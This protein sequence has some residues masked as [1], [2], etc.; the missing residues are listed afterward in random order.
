MS[1]T[2]T[3]EPWVYQSFDTIE[4]SDGYNRAVFE[5]LSCIRNDSEANAKRAV[6][7][8]N[9]C[10]GINPEAL[11]GFISAANA[12]RLNGDLTRFDVAFRALLIGEE[13][14]KEMR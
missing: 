7:C 1:H 12:L 10:A 8:V 11:Q 4:T 5:S 2:H 6:M 9:A 13:A 14:K 3:P